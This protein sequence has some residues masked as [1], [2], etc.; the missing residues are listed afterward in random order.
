MAF[1]ATPGMQQAPEPQEIDKDKV[2]QHIKDV[3]AERQAK[4]VTRYNE[5]KAALM[6]YRGDH[7]WVWS[8]NGEPVKKDIP[9]NIRS[10]STINLYQQIFRTVVANLT[11][12]NLIGQVFPR[13]ASPEAREAAK[14]TQTLLE[15]LVK[16]SGYSNA[17]TQSI[18]WALHA[19]DAYLKVIWD[20]YLNTMVENG[21]AV[22][23]GGVK[24]TAP[25][26]QSIIVDETALTLEDSPWVIH[27]AV[28][29]V[30]KAK[31][32][33]HLDWTPTVDA[34]SSAFSVS[35][36][37][38]AGMNSKSR[39]P[40]AK[41]GVRVLEYWE[42]PS[43]KAP[44][45][46]FGIVINEK[47]V[48]GPRPWPFPRLPFV[49]WKIEEDAGQYK[50]RSFM[51]SLI[52]IQ[53]SINNAFSSVQ[54]YLGKL[55]RPTLLSARGA[56]VGG[57]IEQH[58]GREI[59]EYERTL[60]KPSQLPPANFE[61]W[62]PNFI[63]DM[64]QIM[65]LVSGIGAST[66]GRA[67]FAQAT[68]RAMAFLIEM[69][70][71]K[72]GP[73]A[74]RLSEAIIGVC[75]LMLD[76]QKLYQTEP[77][78]L[79]IENLDGYYDFKEFDREDIDFGDIDID[80]GEIIQS[81][82]AVLHETVEKWVGLGIMSPAEARKILSVGPRSWED[83]DPYAQD[84]AWAKMNIARMLE[85]Q[86]PIVKSYMAWSVH[87]EVTA[88]FMKGKQYLTETPPQTQQVFEQYLTSLQQQAQSNMQAQ[89]QYS[90]S[91][92]QQGPNQPSASSGPGGAS[93]QGG[94]NQG[95]TP[96]LQA[97]MPNLRGQIANS[98]VGGNPQEEN[99]LQQHMNGG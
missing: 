91:G 52:P 51:W 32:K 95:A 74:R 22:V 72:M 78:M 15:Y 99:A 48:D 57:R 53:K 82:Q 27:E 39:Y 35:Q 33:F 98:P 6:M 45:G 7:Q 84:R 38:Q 96:G 55:P 49:H 4:Q 9:V 70:Q 40:Q 85:G 86:Q 44:G 26:P 67:P 56:I 41:S 46:V 83:L 28:M 60:G 5:I 1:A 17:I 90:Q 29:S 63:K 36:L 77:V 92:N 88:A 87:Y 93:G 73:L 42:R 81:S 34:S 62:I 20:P 11:K 54:D 18:H 64:T 76:I 65:D 43:T 8:P 12:G 10:L 80:I 13:N 59:I 47:F 69:D 24:V 23:R 66:Q 61:S 94:G 30:E 97:G 14:A 16:H 19:G 71:T 3:W 37:E 25:C 21:M 75:K 79:R 58:T 68:G 2:L 31:L 89:Q 50:G